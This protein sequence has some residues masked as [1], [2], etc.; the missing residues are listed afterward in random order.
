MKYLALWLEAPLQSWG[1]DSRFDLRDTGKFPTK[2][3]IY[4]LLLAAS[5]DSGA[6][7]E[8]LARMAG[9]PLEVWIMRPASGGEDPGR[10]CDFHMVGNGYDESDSWQTLHIPRTSEGK[11]AVGGGAKLTYRYYLQCQKFAA[12][13]GF[14]DDLAEKFAAALE[15]PVFDL[16][17]GRKCCVP[18]ERIGRG[19]FA[20][21]A[22]A[23]AELLKFA[24]AKMLTPETRVREVELG[25]PGSFSLY[26]VPV[27]FGVHKLYRDRC[28]LPEPF[29]VGAS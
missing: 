27:S 26:D 6:Q 21:A 5:G 14:D 22:E 29:T 18:T 9:A 2:S 16:Y 25:T 3:G 1:Y 7:R 8:L 20:T 17:L 15:T 13:A 10:L 19:L 4:G 24:G 23:E 11:K 12:I 28:V